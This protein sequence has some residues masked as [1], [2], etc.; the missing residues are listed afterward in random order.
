VQ[1]DDIPRPKTRRR[2]PRAISG[3]Q[4]LQPF[5]KEAAQGQMLLWSAKRAPGMEEIINMRFRMVPLPSL[6][7]HPPTTCAIPPHRMSASHCTWTHGCIPPCVLFALVSLSLLGVTQ[8][9][10]PWQVRVAKYKGDK[11][12]AHM[13]LPASR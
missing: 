1:G 5:N 12:E 4:C 7:K 2:L 6:S 9:L 13:K 3:D 10:L 8:L 11:Y